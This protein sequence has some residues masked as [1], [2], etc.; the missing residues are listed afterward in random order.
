MSA[1]P[2]RRRYYEGAT[3]SHS[4]SRPLLVRDRV[5][6]GPPRVRARRSAPGRMEEPPE[7]GPF[8]P[9]EARFRLASAWTGG[10]LTGSLAIHPVPLPGWKTPAD[11][12]VPHQRGPTDAAPRAQHDEGASG[13]MI[14]RLREGFGTRW[15]RLASCV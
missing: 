9:P 13:H 10:D 14:L 5:P 1:V 8:G 6:R 15:L 3:T 7:P 11:S 2:R 12:L 4:A